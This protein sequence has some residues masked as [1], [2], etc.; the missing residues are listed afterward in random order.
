MSQYTGSTIADRVAAVKAEIRAVPKNATNNHANYKYASVD[1]VY[2]AI[3]PLMAE[4]GLDCKMTRIDKEVVKGTKSTWLHMT[5]HIW[6]EAPGLTEE[7]QVRDIALPLTGPQSFEAAVS[8]L[9][10][11]YLRGRFEI[12]TGEYDADEIAP[13]TKD[14]P[15][16]AVA[17]TATLPSVIYTFG[18]GGALEVTPPVEK[19]EGITDEAWNT[20][21]GRACFTRMRTYLSKP[22]LMGSAENLKSIWEKNLFTI[23]DLIPPTG[24]KAL[25]AQYRSSYETLK[26]KEE[27]K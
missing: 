5:F 15:V 22:D 25:G 18:D 9:K 1:D 24:I 6:L 13:A 21:L 17:A 12:E 8:Y 19:P 7:P 11:Q 27:G 14:E 16:A 4:H 2:H 23:N 26:K 20:H 10:K 3:R